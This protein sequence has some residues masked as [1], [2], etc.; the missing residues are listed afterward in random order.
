VRSDVADPLP[1]EVRR[2]ADDVARLP[3]SR[4]ELRGR[5]ENLLRCRWLAL[6][7]RRQTERLEEFASVVAHDLRG[8]LNVA[9]GYVETARSTGDVSDLDPAADALDRA[10]RL[11]DD[12]LTVARQGAGGVDVEPVDL[13]AAVQGAWASVDTGDASLRVETTAEIRADTGQ[14]RQLLENVVRNAVE[15]GTTS[16]RAPSD[17]AVEHGVTDSRAGHGDHVEGSDHLTVR[18]GDLTGRDGF[19]V[20]DDGRGLPADRGDLFERG[21]ST[22]PKGTGFGLAIV[23][24]AATLHG[25]SVRATEAEIGG[26]RFELANVETTGDS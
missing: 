22:A 1:P 12:V 3:L 7:S 19:F 2:R 11:V 23:E 14:L 16:S 5:V 26:A 6:E 8:P 20:E 17:D 15:H 4:V 13:A 24:G 21:V 9:A 25:W 18:V 10:G